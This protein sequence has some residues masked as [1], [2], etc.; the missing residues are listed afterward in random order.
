M[1]L[2]IQL[3]LKMCKF[4]GPAKLCIIIDF[5]IR[6]EPFNFIKLENSELSPLLF[7][8]HACLLGLT[9]KEFDQLWIQFCPQSPFFNL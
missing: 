8:I 6:T 9:I 4:I 2:A 5:L 7:G 1:T 3:P